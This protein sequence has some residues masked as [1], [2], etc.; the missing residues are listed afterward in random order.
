MSLTKSL[1]GVFLITSIA[2]GGVLDILVT[3]FLP[4]GSAVSSVVMCVHVGERYSI[5]KALACTSSLPLL[6]FSNASAD[7][8]ASHREPQRVGTCGYYN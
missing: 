3:F 8:L 2:L 1:L 6:E 5:G 4:V 7:Y